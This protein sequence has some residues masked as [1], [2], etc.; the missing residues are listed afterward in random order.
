MDNIYIFFHFKT[1][2]LIYMYKY[3][4]TY[5][6]VLTNVSVCMISVFE[7]IFQ[8]IFQR[9][10]DNILEFFFSFYIFLCSRDQPQCLQQSTLT[11]LCCQPSELHISSTVPGATAVVSFLLG[12]LINVKGRRWNTQANGWIWIRMD[13]PE[14]GNPITK[15]HT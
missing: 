9:S 12:E 13:H 4:C 5:T 6:H 1:V 2:L 8:S 15:K 10:E 7:G 14:C 3:I 11:E